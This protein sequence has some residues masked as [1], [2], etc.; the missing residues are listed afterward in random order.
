MK[1]QVAFSALELVPL[2]VAI[3]PLAIPVTEIRGVASRDVAAPLS[4]ALNGATLVAGATVSI[5]PT[6]FGVKVEVLSARSVMTAAMSQLPSL[7]TGKVQVC[8]VAVA[9]NEH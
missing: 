6:K 2:T 5:V 8:S 3:S 1:E 9:V 4:C 7:S